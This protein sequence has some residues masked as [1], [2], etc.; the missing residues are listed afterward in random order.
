MGDPDRGSRQL[1]L[2]SLV[3]IGVGGMVGGGIFAVLGLSVE[4]AAGGAPLA[5]LISGLLALATA[6]SYALLSRSYPS[7]GGTVT[8]INRAFGRGLFAG[9]INI[10]LWLSYIV[11]LALY[12]QA[13]GSYA[14]SFLPP[15]DQA[16]AKHAFLSAVV[17]VITALNAAGAST[18]ARAERLIVAVKVA[19]LLVFVVVGWASISADR[20]APAQWSAPLSLVAGGMIVFLA[21]EGFE[22]IANAAE[23]VA[24]PQRTLPRAFY[25][26]VSLVIVLYVL[27]AIVAVGAVPV[28]D[29]VD[30]R[31]YAL[32]V[33]AKPGLGAAGFTLIGVAAMLSTASAINATLYG[34]SRLSYTIAKSG[35]LPELLE[36]PIWNKPLEGLLI[37]AGLTL[38]LANVLDLTAIATM[39]SAGFLIIFAIVNAAEA[40]TSSQR[41][42]RAWVS[43][44]AGLAC[45]AALATLVA[46][47]SL[48]ANA[49]LAGMLALSFGIEALYRRAG[50]GPL[51]F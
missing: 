15:A 51:T 11:M 4:I 48:G 39:G 23:D 33:A 44:A 50:R 42:T 28:A 5:F 45:L 6:R 41:G 30:A 20:L 2:W 24:D 17:L 14:A 27:V 25:L 19:I 1:G 32:A 31:D 12:A 9:G 35:E 8:F 16:I 40:R 49:V 10:L 36:R 13:F 29:L 18:V 34:S 7:R 47:S 22:L 37:T 3:S 21:Y 26:T 46:H 38:A 43:A